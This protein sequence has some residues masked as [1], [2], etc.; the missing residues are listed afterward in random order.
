EESGEVTDGE[1]HGGGDGGDE[2]LPAVQSEVLAV[3]K[4]AAVLQ[5]PPL[6]LRLPP[7]RRPEEVL[8]AQGGRPAVR[9]QVLRLLRRRGPRHRRLRH[10]IPPLL[11]RPRVIS[12]PTTS[13][14]ACSSPLKQTQCSV[15]LYNQQSKHPVSH[16][17]CVYKSGFRI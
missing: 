10:R 15:T 16:L 12:Q 8:R 6:I 14:L 13:T 11:R 4:H 3:G 9:R 1:R 5:V 17:D 7:P 2:G